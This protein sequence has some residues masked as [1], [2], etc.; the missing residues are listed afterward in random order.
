VARGDPVNGIG[1]VRY[2]DA[3]SGQLV[4]KS[5]RPRA[6]DR[7]RFLQRS[8]PLRQLVGPVDGRLPE[9]GAVGVI[10]RGEDLAP[11]AVEDGKPRIVEPNCTG[12]GVC[13]GVCPAPAN[14]ISITPLADRRQ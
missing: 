12:C 1:V 8:D 4:P 14:A 2:P 10:Q 11:P 3:V 7:W 6:G 5:Y 9:P 13:H